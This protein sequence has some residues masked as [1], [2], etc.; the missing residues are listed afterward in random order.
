VFVR[1][2]KDKY[3][4]AATV[5]PTSNLEPAP[6]SVSANIT[7]PFGTVSLDVRRQGS[8][9]I[10]TTQAEIGKTQEQ[11]QEQVNVHEH[12]Q[13]RNGG[14]VSAVTVVQLDKWHEASHFSR[15][16]KHL[17]LE[18]ELHDDHVQIASSTADA[19]LTHPPPLP[20]PLPRTEIGAA[21]SHLLDFTEAVTYMPLEK[22][23]RL[24][25][26]VTPRPL[27]MDV[28]SGLMH[29]A[30][31]HRRYAVR[32]CLRA[33]S[34]GGARLVVEVNA[35]KVTATAA[36][37]P[38][39]TSSGGGASDGT[40]KAFAWTDATTKGGGGAWFELPTGTS[41]TVW[42]EADSGDVDVDALKLVEIG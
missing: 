40:D 4:V 42:V 14:T 24:A 21:A 32:A 18:A 13:G 8:V 16:S 22:G 15:W 19:L 34:L 41:S 9:Y 28:S 26:T 2:L 33:T 3:V 30:R 5:Q 35:T 17:Q 10:I 6:Y 29:P 7:L 38:A 39:A 12:E 25:F 36:I 11:E 1:Q 31:T 23:Q 20:F 27:S 37:A